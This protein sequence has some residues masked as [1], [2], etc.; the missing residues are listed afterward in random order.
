MKKW[1][2]GLIGLVI[3][4]GGLAAGGYFWWRPRVASQSIVEAADAFLAGRDNN[5][6]LEYDKALD[7]VDKAI[8]WGKYDST[9]GI[10]RGQVLAGLSRYD[11][12]RAQYEK[13]LAA[14]PSA[15]EA[16]EDLLN[17]LP[18]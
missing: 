9:I 17:Q 13:I 5:D 8:A 1:H 10:F 3:I 4:V 14:D 2:F 11:E 18:Q 7:L 12:A 16:V 6:I 15:K